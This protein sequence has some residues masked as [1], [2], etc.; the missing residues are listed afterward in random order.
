MGQPLMGSML[1]RLI[2]LSSGQ[3]ITCADPKTR[4]EYAGTEL[5]GSLDFGRENDLK[6]G[7]Q[8]KSLGQIHSLFLSSISRSTDRIPVPQT[9]RHRTLITRLSPIRLVLLF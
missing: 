8:L 1:S 4:M 7:N 3:Q 2:D 5:C 9:W 6:R